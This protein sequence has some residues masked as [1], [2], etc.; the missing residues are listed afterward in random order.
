MRYSEAFEKEISQIQEEYKET[1]E[2]KEAVGETPSK[3]QLSE[4][5]RSEKEQLLKEKL[6][7]LKQTYDEFDEIHRYYSVNAPTADSGWYYDQKTFIS[8]FIANKGDDYVLNIISNY[9]GEDWIFID[10]VTIK[11]DGEYYSP[12]SE[13]MTPKFEREICSG[14]Y[15][16]ESCLNSVKTLDNTLTNSQYYDI[17]KKMVDGNDVVVRFS[18]KNGNKDLIIDKDR[19]AIREVLEAWDIIEELYGQSKK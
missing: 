18:G 10:D 7:K 17:L 6:S 11:I 1:D 13:L 9:Y 19:Q 2:Y 8:P 14:G 5:E 16:S 3:P 12:Y 4:A 15:V